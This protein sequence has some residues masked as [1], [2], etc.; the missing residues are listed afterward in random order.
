[1][2]LT[3]C[4]IQ[5]VIYSLEK[6][7]VLSNSWSII[8]QKALERDKPDELKPVFWLI[9]PGSKGQNWAQEFNSLHFDKLEI[10]KFS[11]Y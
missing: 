10:I 3:V 9:D 8:D 6:L 2:H 5:Y 7:T 4:N 1:M 11:I